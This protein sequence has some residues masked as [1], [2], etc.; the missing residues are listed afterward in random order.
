MNPENKSVKQKTVDEL[1]KDIQSMQSYK[2]EQEQLVS[3]GLAAEAEI[4]KR[5][6]HELNLKAG[7]DLLI[8]R[9]G[10]AIINKANRKQYDPTTDVIFVAVVID[11][12]FAK[13][14]DEQLDEEATKNLVNIALEKHLPSG[15]KL[16]AISLKNMQKENLR[17]FTDTFTRFTTAISFHNKSTAAAIQKKYRNSFAFNPA[18]HLPPKE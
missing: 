17:L 5:L 13:S 2:T 10:Q 16:T 15:A 9:E 4:S 14:P 7:Y 3:H 18:K 8:E 6:G 11:N 1:E 12:N